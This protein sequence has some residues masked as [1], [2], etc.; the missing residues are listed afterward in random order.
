MVSRISISHAHANI[1][2]MGTTKKSRA[3]VNF[4]SGTMFG[5]NYQGH[6]KNFVNENSALVQGLK[7]KRKNEW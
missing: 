2:T 4:I 6:K 5:E 7:K 3:D 1:Y